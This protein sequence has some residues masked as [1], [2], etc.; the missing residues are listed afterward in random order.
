MP[1]SC[2]CRNWTPAWRAAN[3]T[4]CFP[5]GIGVAGRHYLS[6]G[7]AAIEEVI[8]NELLCRAVYGPC[9]HTLQNP[10]REEVI[11]ETYVYVARSLMIV[12]SGID[13]VSYRQIILEHHLYYVVVHIRIFVVD[14]YAGGKHIPQY[15]PFAG[16]SGNRFVVAGRITAFH[17]FGYADERFDISFFSDSFIWS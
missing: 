10:E 14:G 4:V 16:M 6:V 15:H 9:T 3:R 5:D 12:V 11:A 8:Q 17:C 7:T 2:L 1:D 13:V